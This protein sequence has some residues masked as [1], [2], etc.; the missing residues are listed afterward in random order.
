MSK[1]RISS[2]LEDPRR[3]CLGECTVALCSLRSSL[4][5]G[6]NWISAYC[7]VCGSYLE[8]DG[9][10]LVC[11]DCGSQTTFDFCDNV[12]CYSQAVTRKDDTSQH[13][14]T[15]NFLKL[16]TDIVYWF[17]I[18]KV[19]GAATS[20]LERSNKL[21]NKAEKSNRGPKPESNSA[22]DSDGKP[23]SGLS[24]ICISCSDNISRPCWY[25]IDCSGESSLQSLQ[26]FIARIQQ[27][28]RT[29]LSARIVATSKTAS[30]KQ[31]TR[32]I[33]VS[34]A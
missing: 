15:H 26:H 11:I 31:I 24:F 21:L 17:E 5:R 8:S 2:S 13:L 19:L 25:C 10:R 6:Y 16:R 22:G 23:K 32:S 27:P 33:T 14:P 18:G 29:Y 30:I 9:P 12:S 20:G 28:T 4:T 3:R 1:H 34:S 7:D